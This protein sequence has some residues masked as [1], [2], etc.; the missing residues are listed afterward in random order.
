[1]GPDIVPTFGSINIRELDPRDRANP[2]LRATR[3]VTETIIPSRSSDYS[4]P[5]ETGSARI[6]SKNVEKHRVHKFDQ[7]DIDDGTGDWVDSVDRNK[8][9]EKDRERE[10]HYSPINSI[11]NDWSS[12]SHVEREVA[13]QHDRIKQF[14]GHGFGE[15]DDVIQHARLDEVEGENPMPGYEQALLHPPVHGE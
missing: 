15:S 13:K 8:M 7:S 10:F 1:M 3:K 12:G 9:R 2:A 14:F 6:F 4:S 5:S 11:P